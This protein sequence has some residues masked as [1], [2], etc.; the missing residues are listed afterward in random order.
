MSLWRVHQ[1]KQQHADNYRGRRER[2]NTQRFH[3]TLR[4]STRARIEFDSVSFFFPRPRFFR[5]NTTHESGR[6][7]DFVRV[8][9]Q[10]CLYV[11]I[12]R[13]TYFYFSIR[14][15]YER[16]SSRTAERERGREREREGERQRGETVYYTRS[17][18]NRKNVDL[19]TCLNSPRDT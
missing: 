12:V 3:K 11:N 16:E 7:F 19:R 6:V 9:R 14:K 4:E 13:S 10:T 18:G 15:N 5:A 17:G 2:L 8:S 1:Y